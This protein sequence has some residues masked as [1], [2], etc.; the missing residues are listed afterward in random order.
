VVQVALDMK[1]TWPD[2]LAAGRSLQE[3]LGTRVRIVPFG[4]PPEKIVGVDAAFAG[5]YIIAVASMYRYS[6]LEHLEDAVNGEK[7]EFPYVPCY[8]AFREGHAIVL[9]VKKL[10]TRPDLIL[11]D[12]HGIAHPRGF[13]I[14]SHIGVLFDVPTVGCAKSRLIG[15][16]VEPGKRKGDWTYLSY[17]GR[18][19][20]AVLRTR[21]DVKPVFVSPGHMI[22]IP[23][24]IG[25][26]MHCVSR[27]RVPDPLRCAD[28]LSKQFSKAIS[29]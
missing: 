5:S 2:T 10:K 11:V 1:E 15:E 12:G 9:A 24:A 27:Y 14:A 23:S 20:G 8:L 3:R 22:D 21:E 4:K 29:G 26:V 18:N 25:V 17:R 19:V 6:S 13:G 28:H 16:F 7:T